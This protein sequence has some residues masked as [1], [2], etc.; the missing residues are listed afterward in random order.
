[1]TQSSDETSASVSYVAPWLER[2][3]QISR[4][5]AI[6]TEGEQKAAR[7]ADELSQVMRDFRSKEQT[8]QENAV[9]IE[10]M[11]KRAE[12]VKQQVEALNE[13]EAELAKAKKQEKAYE[14]ALEALHADM[15]AIEK[16]NVKLK[17]NP[18]PDGSGTSNH[19]RE[20]TGNSG[21]VSSFL[22]GN[23]EA[24]AL[25]FSG[26][27]E[28][29]QLLTTIESLRGSV[30]YL[31]RENAFLQSRDLAADLA[32][33]KPIKLATAEPVKNARSEHARKVNQDVKALWKDALA[34]ASMPKVVDFSSTKA[35][36]AQSRVRQPE[37]QMLKQKEALDKLASRMRS[38]TFEVEALSLPNVLAFR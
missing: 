38:L 31:Q 34:N 7:L 13:I 30:R 26:S 32:S 2:V 1:M 35:E 12:H 11:E 8:L 27:L 29:A 37:L 20:G 4:A 22:A 28:T 10:L 24:D 16:E 21:V 9:K 19:H 6:N 25:A 33:L 14:E 5:N 36:N 17:Q 15:E 23:T 18:V 3:A